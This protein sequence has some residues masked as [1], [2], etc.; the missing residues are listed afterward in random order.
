MRKQTALK[1]S[2]SDFETPWNALEEASLMLEMAEDEG[3]ESAFDDTEELLKT[4]EDGVEHLEFQRMLGGP[5][6]RS[7]A[8]V[9][10]N[11]GAGGLESQDWASML[12]RMYLRWCDSKSFKSEIVEHTSGDE[13]GIKS[14][15]FTVDGEFAF[16]YLRAEAGVHRLVRISPFDASARRHTSFASVFVYPEINDDIEIEIN[17]SEVRVDT[18]RASGAGGQHVNK[19]DSAVRLTHLPT[20]LVVQCQSQ[21]SQH[22]N[23][24]TA[25]K[26][27][28]SRLYALELE[29]REKS[30]EAEYSE[31]KEIN[32][33]S[34]IRSY[35][36][37]PYRMV[38]DHRTNHEMGNTDAVL[39][40]ALDD[41]MKAFLLKAGGAGDSQDE[42]EG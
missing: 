35:V 15:T 22:K 41:F 16:G 42:A 4:S 3:E 17:E 20:G 19:T 12:F 5:A 7:N 26:L 23:R 38:K 31:K 9:Q 36:L 24:A 40:G 8:I 28:K 30:M 10:I 25:F 27:L 14:A 33:G 34:Q 6:D 18:Y 1:T 21:R 39:D 2:I 37:H 29:A 32:F 13:A 11:S